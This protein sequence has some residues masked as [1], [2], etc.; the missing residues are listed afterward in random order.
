VRDAARRPYL[1]VPRYVMHHMARSGEPL[2]DTPHGAGAARG[3]G[4]TLF[5]LLSGRA[6]DTAVGVAFDSDG[7]VLAVLRRPSRDRGPVLLACDRIAG[8]ELRGADLKP[9]VGRNRAGRVPAVALLAAG[10]YQVIQIDAPPVPAAEMRVAAG[11]R[12]RDLIDY[13]LEQAVIDT[14][15]LPEPAQRGTARINVVAARRDLVAERLARMRAAGFALQAIDIPELAQGEAGNRLP[16]DERGHALLALERASGLITIARDNEQYLARPLDA[17]F[18]DIARGEDGIDALVLEV[19]RSFD[20]FESAMSQPPVGV[21][22]LHPAGDDMDTLAR[23]IESG[24]GTI[25]CKAIAVG[26]L[27]EVQHEPGDAGATMLHAIGASLRRVEAS[28]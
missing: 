25:E 18:A 23:A 15:A 6:R 28:A 4:Q 9:W 13:P 11:W 26:D 8:R 16:A 7:V 14:F 2:P 24:L 5:S 21:L 12:I 10:E 20:Y 3:R 1:V 19:Q 17:G 27:V 22:Y